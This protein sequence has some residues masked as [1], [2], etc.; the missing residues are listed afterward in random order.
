MATSN[1]SW[2]LGR[3]SCCR[4]RAHGTPVAVRFK[5]PDL[6]VL[7]VGEQLRILPGIEFTRPDNMR[8]V[9]IGVVVDPLTL[10]IVGRP[11]PDHDELLARHPFQSLDKSDW[12]GI[13]AIPRP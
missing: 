10:K 3:E 4:I 8:C 5:Q 7:V 6:P 9:D 1:P 13:S 11:V 2:S 12:C